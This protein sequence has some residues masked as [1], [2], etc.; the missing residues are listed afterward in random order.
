MNNPLSHCSYIYFFHQSG[1]Q[2]HQN[3]VSLDSQEDVKKEQDVGVSFLSKCWSLSPVRLF[4]T[5]WTIATH[6]TPQA[7]ILEQV[8]IS[9]SRGSS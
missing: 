5:S 3:W 9:F 2:N 8:A 1:K 6:G 4:V 7:K